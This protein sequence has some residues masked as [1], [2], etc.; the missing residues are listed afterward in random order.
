[1]VPPHPF[2]R[3]R[4]NFP[5]ARDLMANELASSHSYQSYQRQRQLTLGDLL[6]AGPL[7]FKAADYFEFED[8]RP[9]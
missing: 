7:G 5:L 9:T 8:S 1:M 3:H 4:M 2:E 6:L